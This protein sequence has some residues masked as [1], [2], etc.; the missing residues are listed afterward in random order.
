M[1]TQKKKTTTKGKT[2]TRSKTG[3]SS[4]SNTSSKKT[5]KGSDDRVIWSAV[6]FVLGLL[7][8]AFTL[9]TGEDLWL[10]MHNI[11]LGAFGVA[12]ILV[13]VVLIYAAIMLAKDKEKNAVVGKVMQG[14]IMILVLSAAAEIFASDTHAP[15]TA[16]NKMVMDLMENG[17]EF[18]GGG[19]FSIVLGIPLLKLFGKT[20]ASIIIVLLI[21]FLILLLSNKTIVDVLRWFRN[22]GALLLESRPEYQPVPENAPVRKKPVER[23]EPVRTIEQKNAE[24]APRKE[25]KSLFGGL[26]SG[27]KKKEQ[28]TP[29]EIPVDIAEAN[30]RDFD[31]DI[32]FPFEKRKPEKAEQKKPRSGLE[33]FDYDPVFDVPDSPAVSAVPDTSEAPSKSETEMEVERYQQQMDMERRKRAYELQKKRVVGQSTDDVPAPADESSSLDE[34]IRKASGS[35]AAQ[36]V[37]HAA[38]RAEPVSP[39]VDD[40]IRRAAVPAAPAPVAPVAPAPVSAPVRPA[41]VMDARPVPPKHIKASTLASNQIGDDEDLDLPETTAKDIQNE[42]AENEPAVI[43]YQIPPMGLLKPSK[44]EAN[45]DQAAVEMR[46]NSETLLSTLKSFN[47]EAEIVD[48]K[49][50]PTVTRY[51]LLPKAGIEIS[52]IRQLSDDIAMRLATNGGVRIEAP[53]PGKAAVGIEVP[54]KI[55]D[56]VA[57]RD[58]LDTEEFSNNR[59]KLTFAVGKNI[60]G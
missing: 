46:E 5:A 34:I 57:I 17:R 22:M 6:L 42:I 12:S 51:E 11:L 2:T 19:L 28:D 1:P 25:R 3:T 39:S 58:V 49:R 53:I 29:K 54:N 4:R 18:K 8:L 33:K 41:P 16:F 48:I 36:P 27:T 23:K 26:F 59:S 44:N 7:T 20:G 30:R 50:G 24:P 47:I 52:K 56:V 35:T 14:I 31:V 32:A 60:D 38:D 43:E 40:L 13:P 15:D 10:T 21:L 55:K 45:S 9:V 37:S